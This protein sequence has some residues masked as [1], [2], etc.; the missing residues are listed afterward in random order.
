[1]SVLN[2]FTFLCDLYRNQPRNGEISQSLRSIGT[3]F[4]ER[5]IS[6]SANISFPLMVTI[7]ERL[8]CSLLPLFGNF[9]R[10]KQIFRALTGDGNGLK[11]NAMY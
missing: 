9:E 11:L 6:G 4:T 10:K 1:M 5:G 3:D 2:A 7:P 8:T